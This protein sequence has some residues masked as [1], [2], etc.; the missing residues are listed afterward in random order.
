MKR[1]VLIASTV[2]LVWLLAFVLLYNTKAIAA[3]TYYGG[4]VPD[5]YPLKL[6]LND[7]NFR[8]KA[9]ADTLYTEE[10]LA[11]SLPAEPAVLL[12][13]AAVDFV[14]HFKA[15]YSGYYLN[16]RSKKLPY[17]MTIEDIL[18]GYGLPV[19]LKY[20][21]V[22]ESKL[23]LNAVSKAGA[24]GPWQFMPVTAKYLGLRINNKVDERKDIKKSTHAAAKYLRDLYNEFG[25]WLLVLAA[26]NS[27]PGNVH[28]AIRLSGSKD[29]WKLQQYLPKETRNHV[30]KYIA[31]HYIYEDRGSL[32]TL[33]RTEVID[34][35][36]ITA[37]HLVNRKL[38]QEE[39]LDVERM[40]IGN[41][42]NAA[43]I[44][45][46]IDME[47]QE[48]NRYNPKFDQLIACSEW[49]D[50]YLPSD[51]MK[52]FVSK[53]EPQENTLADSSANYAATIQ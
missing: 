29:F 24:V 26:Y 47:Q 25:D 53:T 50:L 48:F 44:A 4:A 13:P 14:E 7:S 27:G 38:T 11:K 46:L 20:L 34:Q 23:N 6:I 42:Y 3:N 9:Y 40:T 51:K 8:A 16:I 37:T 10:D 52:M 5:N 21:A 43:A 12:N 45:E 18:E 1:K 35:F 39:K 22:I 41:E 49:Y 32:V 15:N 30:K 28:K 19:E 33:T 36:G 17:L 31:T 2:S